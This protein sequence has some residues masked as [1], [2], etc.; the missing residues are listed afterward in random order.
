M[1]NSLIEKPQRFS[2]KIVVF[3]ILILSYF[4]FTGFSQTGNSEAEKKKRIEAVRTD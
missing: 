1:I 2:T 3:L 4:S